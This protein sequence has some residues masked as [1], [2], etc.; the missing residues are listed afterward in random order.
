[1]PFSIITTHGPKGFSE[2]TLVPDGWIQ[3]T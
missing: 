2:L 3:T 1:M